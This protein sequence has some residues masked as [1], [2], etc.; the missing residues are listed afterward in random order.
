MFKF[1]FL[2]FLNIGIA[3]PEA[4]F[5]DPDFIPQSWIYEFG[6]CTCM[7][8]IQVGSLHTLQPG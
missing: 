2:M 5:V 4:E 6:Y 8:I 7:S 1:F 3:Y